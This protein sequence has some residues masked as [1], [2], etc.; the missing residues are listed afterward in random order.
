MSREKRRGLR[1]EGRWG[2]CHLGSVPKKCVFPVSL[3]SHILHLGWWSIACLHTVIE[4]FI[5]SLPYL[6]IHSKSIYSTS[7]MCQIL[8]EIL[9]HEDD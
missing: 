9:V 5:F 7:T 4:S 6:L 8:S 2:V 1:I 3:C